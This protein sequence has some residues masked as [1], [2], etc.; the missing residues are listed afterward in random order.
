MVMPPSL[1]PT[2][3]LHL[4]KLCEHLVRS[5]QY[6]CNEMSSR[7]QTVAENSA[8]IAL[9]HTSVT[10]RLHELENLV[11]NLT[12][13]AHQM[14]RYKLAEVDVSAYVQSAAGATTFVPPKESACLFVQYDVLFGEI[15]KYL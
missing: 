2:L 10:L 15:N 4:A 12:T 3:T 14:A 11:L 8:R 1:I 13:L 6:M 9:D 7:M 5:E